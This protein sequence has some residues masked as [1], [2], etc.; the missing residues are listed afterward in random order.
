MFPYCLCSW[1]FTPGSCLRRS[2]VKEEIQATPVYTK[3][4]S[5]SCCGE[6]RRTWRNLFLPKW[7][8]F[9]VWRWALSRSSI[10]SKSIV[11][12]MDGVA[13]HQPRAWQLFCL[14]PIIRWI[15][16]RNYKALSKGVKGSTSGFLNIMMELKKCCNH[17]YLIRAP[18]DDLNKTE[19]LQVSSFSFTCTLIYFLWNK[20][21]YRVYRWSL[22]FPCDVAR[23]VVCASSCG[24]S[25]MVGVNKYVYIIMCCSCSQSNWSAAV[26][27]WFCWTSC[28]SVWRSVATEF[29]SSLRWFGCWISLLTIWGA[30]SSSF[31]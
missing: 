1:G 28:S 15:L 14:L 25:H 6:S 29:S 17:C 7:S 3:S 12:H 18:E 31:R 23:C 21:L 16:T 30:D 20:A 4:W 27:N 26:G 22:L 19:A 13:L 9:Y 5:L 11:L 8:R 2:T 10:T 24:Y